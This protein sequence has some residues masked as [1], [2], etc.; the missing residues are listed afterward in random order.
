MVVEARLGSPIRSTFEAPVVLP[1]PAGGRKCMLF[2][3]PILV[4]KDVSGPS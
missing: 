1:Q 3:V 4:N 2:M